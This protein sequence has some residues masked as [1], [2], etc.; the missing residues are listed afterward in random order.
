MQ[1]L[2]SF[3]NKQPSNTA[4]FEQERPQ[5]PGRDTVTTLQWPKYGIQHFLKF[6]RKSFWLDNKALVHF[7]TTLGVEICKHHVARPLHSL[8]KC[9]ASPAQKSQGLRVVCFK[10]F[11][12]ATFFCFLSQLVGGQ[13]FEQFAYETNLKKMRSVRSQFQ[14]I[15]LELILKTSR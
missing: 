14:I 3:W 7:Y 2:K 15:F 6:C 8:N 5:T 11:L 13:L 4:T 12:R 9:R 1:P 10:N